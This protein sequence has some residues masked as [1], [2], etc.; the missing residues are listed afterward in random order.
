MSITKSN[1]RDRSD[2]PPDRSG[3]RKNA[4]DQQVRN[5]QTSEEVN[6]NEERINQR[7]FQSDVS[8]RE[9]RQ[10]ANGLNTPGMKNTK[11]GN[12]S[13]VRGS[14][15]TRERKTYKTDGKE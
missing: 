3:S 1:D 10:N 5:E 11:T 12:Q 8:E 9:S 4:T 14:A 7:S 13:D 15:E 6:R 2:S